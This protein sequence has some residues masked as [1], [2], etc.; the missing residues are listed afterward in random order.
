M[1]RVIYKRRAARL[2]INGVEICLGNWYSEQRA[3]AFC[4]IDSKEDETARMAHI[5]D[6]WISYKSLCTTND[7]HVWFN[8]QNWVVLCVVLYFCK[9]FSS[10]FFCLSVWF[11]SF[12]SDSI[13]RFYW[14]QPRHTL[15]LISSICGCCFFFVHFF[16]KNLHFDRLAIAHLTAAKPI[17][18]VVIVVFIV[19]TTQP[20]EAEA[21][22][23]ILMADFLNIGRNQVL[24]NQFVCV[25]VCAQVCYTRKSTAKTKLIKQQ[26]TS[27]PKLRLFFIV[28]CSLLTSVSCLYHFFIVCW[29]HSLSKLSVRLFC[30]FV[31]IY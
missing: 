7:L 19:A 31:F 22:N 18:N 4:S 30:S 15:V 17:L 20:N 9:Y 13:I 10:I 12:I 8:W 6:R 26:Q 23:H 14:T 16:S 29:L 24:T 1:F 11:C 28:I 3:A 27:M 21:P 2:T 5:I 25:C